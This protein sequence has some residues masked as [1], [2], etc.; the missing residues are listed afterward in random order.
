VKNRRKGKS[1]AALDADY[2][3]EDA[4]VDAFLAAAAQAVLSSE[5][6]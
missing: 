6:W 1:K 2:A 3:L 4:E 5:K